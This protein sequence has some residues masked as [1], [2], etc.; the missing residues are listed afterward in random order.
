MKYQRAI[1]NQTCQ[2][3]AI[4]SA[5]HQIKHLLPEVCAQLEHALMLESILL[6]HEPI[7]VISPDEKDLLGV[8]NLQSQQ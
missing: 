8:K 2:R 4:E 7:F 6:I 3:Q 5:L 1:R